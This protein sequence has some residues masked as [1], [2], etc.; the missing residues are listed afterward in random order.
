MR[1]LMH[2]KSFPC[3]SIPGFGGVLC[4]LE[5]GVSTEVAGTT[6]VVQG[7]TATAAATVVSTTQTDIR[8]CLSDPCHNGAICQ[9]REGFF[10]CLC[11]DGM[12]K[13]LFS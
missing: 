8:E 11:A 13:F 6:T 4:E 12:T 1:V 9:D 2:Q 5:V 3:I 7:S 10:I